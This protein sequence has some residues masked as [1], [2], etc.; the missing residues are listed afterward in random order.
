MAPD[1]PEG[2]DSEPPPARFS[3]VNGLSRVG[4]EPTTLGLKV[5]GSKQNTRQISYLLALLA[6][7]H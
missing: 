3:L 1:G 5:L 6:V 7:T 2:A 4:I